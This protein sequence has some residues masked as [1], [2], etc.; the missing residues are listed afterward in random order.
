MHCFVLPFPFLLFPRSL[1]FL[2]LL[3]LL[4]FRLHF[5]FPSSLPLKSLQFFF[6]LRLFRVLFA[7]LICSTGP[8]CSVAG[9]VQE[10]DPAFASWALIGFA[11]TH[12]VMVFIIS[13][14]KLLLAKRASFWFH[15]TSFVVIAICIL[16]S[17][18]ATVRTGHYCVLFFLMLF[19]FCLGYA[20]FALF[21]SVVLSSAAD[22]M[23]PELADFDVFLAQ[24]AFLC[25][26]L[27]LGFH[28]KKYI[29]F[30]YV[31]SNFLNNNP[32]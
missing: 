8:V 10:L 23:H 18:E 9:L 31:L 16:R 17:W 24:G 19:L 13:D 25:F 22:V 26:Y 30:V 4:P 12:I 6:L 20:L 11:S 21:A 2:R 3:L 32:K 15:V 14:S 7:L 28:F 1:P 5:D 29:L 27:F